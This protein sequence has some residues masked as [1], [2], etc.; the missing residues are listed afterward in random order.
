MA[1]QNYLGEI[2]GEAAALKQINQ[3]LELLVHNMF[4]ELL[5]WKRKRVAN[6]TITL[7]W[8]NGDRKFIAGVF[9]PKGGLP[10][11]QTVPFWLNVTRNDAGA[12]EIKSVSKKSAESQAQVD[13]RQTDAF[14]AK[15]GAKKGSKK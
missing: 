14:A 15:E 1:P 4:N 11:C 3:A 6:F 7:E 13:P 9:E 8:M 2:G 12:I 10:L 5:P